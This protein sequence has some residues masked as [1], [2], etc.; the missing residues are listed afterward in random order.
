M[1][2]I[3]NLV[4][5]VVL[6]LFVTTTKA[7]L[8]DVQIAD[9]TFD[10]DEGSYGALVFTINAKAGVGYTIGQPTGGDFGALTLRLDMEVPS[11]AGLDLTN[12]SCAVGTNLSLNTVA[13]SS[14][15][16]ANSGN[17]GIQFAITRFTIDFAGG[18]KDLT[19]SYQKI[20]TC[21]IPLTS[22]VAAADIGD[23]ALIIRTSALGWTNVG[24]RST[25]TSAGLVP[26][27]EVNPSLPRYP[28][29]DPD[30]CTDTAIATDISVGNSTFCAGETVSLTASL[31]V[32]NSIENPVY[33][34]Y[35]DQ[36]TTTGVTGDTYAP[37]GATNGSKYY[38]S[39][40]GDDVCENAPGTRKEVTVTIKPRAV[41]GD[42]EVTGTT[43][44]CADTGTELTASI[45]LGSLVIGTPS[46]QWYY[47][48]GNPIP[49]ATSAIY[50][51]GSLS[52][53]TTYYVSVSST[54][55]CEN[56]ATNRK[57]VALTVKPRAVAGDIEVTGTT[58]I[59]A[60]T[61]TELTASIALGSLVI[62]TPSYQWYYS[63]G[64]PIPGATSAIYNT[65]SLSANTTYYVSVSSTSHCENL[66]SARKS[67]AVKVK[68]YATEDMITSVSGTSVCIVGD[69]TTLT[70]SSTIAGA[71]FKWYDSSQNFIPGATNATYSIASVSTPVTYYVTVSGDD[72]CESPLKEVNVTIGALLKTSILPTDT[73]ICSGG[74]ATLIAAATGA[75]SY[76]WYRAGDGLVQTSASDT[77]SASV[78]GSYTVT[79]TIGSCISPVSDAVTVTVVTGP[80]TV[81]GT[82]EGLADYTGV[83]VGYEINGVAQTPVSVSGTGGYIITGVPC[84][85]KLEII[86]SNRTGYTKPG[87]IILG[88]VLG[89]I[90]DQDLEYE[91]QKRNIDG[92]VTGVDNL[93][94][95]TVC[96]SYPAVA[97]AFPAVTNSCVTTDA[98]GKYTL[99][100]IPHGA[101]VEITSSTI[102]SGSHPE[103]YDILTTLSTL[104]FT[105]D[106]T[107]TGQEVGDIEYSRKT[108]NVSGAITGLPAAQRPTT[109]TVT[110]TD[111]NGDP[112]TIT[113]VTVNPSDG[114]YTIT[115]IP[116][117]STDLTVDAAGVTGYTKTPGTV[118]GP[119]TGNETGIN[120]AYT[121]TGGP[122]PTFRWFYISSPYADATT[123]GFDIP[124]G[125]IGTPSLTGGSLLGYYS[126]ADKKYSAPFGLGVTFTPALGIVA[127]LDVNI[128]EFA[129][130]TI[131]TFID[132]TVFNTGSYSP[133]VT[134]SGGGTKA[135]KNL[136]G[137][138]YNERIDFDGLIALGSN[139]DVIEPSYW[140]RYYTGSVMAFESY[141]T[142]IGGGTGALTSI[143]PTVQAFW[144]CSK[145]AS[146]NV[147]FDTS[148]KTGISP[149]P[150]YRS[151]AAKVSRIARLRI[152]SAEQSDEMLLA[153]N[154]GASNSYDAYKTE[155][156]AND[157]DSKIPEI[158][159]KLGNRELS[160]NGLPPVG[161]DA[162][163]T[164][165]LG[166][167]TV[168]TGSFTISS[169]FENWDNTRIYLRD[170]T[171]NIETELTAGASYSFT[172]GVYD[173]T[174][175]F[176]IVIQGA[177]LGVN[178]LEHNTKIFVNEKNRIVVETDI[179][180]AECAVY[181]ALG[182]QLTSGTITLSPQ[183]LD[184]VLEAGVYLV[185]VG[186]KT[187]RVI[188]K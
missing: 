5:V 83:T 31:T 96:Y 101:V 159:T 81:S 179:P 17:V 3:I 177:P 4:L 183:T 188:I 66:T 22:T 181:N 184:C 9:F 87:N 156:M 168:E 76:S 121:P 85:A 134:N 70:A 165:P 90:T 51:T 171:T 75:D 52:A 119:I 13:G 35:A 91:V 6:S 186:N 108:Y 176:S 56:L 113:G 42:I 64:D 126:E 161:S 139:S 78:A 92:Y 100:Q 172:S 167:R 61:G 25:W 142:T 7:Q 123:L 153:L 8:I 36:T 23:F 114:T 144:V 44:I 10:P 74:S 20:A 152:S 28:I 185:K 86:P 24:R 103:Y 130:P 45:A 174:N 175:R 82:V 170:N 102:P 49:G 67:V 105:A 21:T 97:G 120:V 160:I 38:V 1:K 59:C 154:P 58:T 115:G 99:P 151:P 30:P 143:I 55:H 182:Q 109:V 162:E 32:A 147:L 69:P 133:T 84:G 16:G 54:S 47:S 107:N 178:A 53:N 77:Y 46:Y 106:V 138:P 27:L 122:S 135:G 26:Q 2:K 93:A 62:G 79:Y 88:K 41:A 48:N 164:V 124:S 60:N 104:T 40:E 131:A 180:N 11:G 12:I 71:S 72:Y 39:V 94:G 37:S 158:Y 14:T 146:G 117:G 63:N 112:Q 140:I 118:T 19:T 127:E 125:T 50:N 149:A 132:G 173:N 111:N 15:G 110:Y 157:A 65:G 33:T 29:E 137:N 148:I 18:T 43:T 89:N 187:E 80:F 116:Y 68:N 73:T 166:F 145:V 150:A 95:V 163:V 57:S 128:P 169:T 98:S 129:P 155:K 136:L 141:N 34:W